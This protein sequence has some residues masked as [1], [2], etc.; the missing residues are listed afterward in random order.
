MPTT[1]ADDAPAAADRAPPAW[2][3]LWV[4]LAG[5]PA[6]PWGV[7]GLR[8]L[9]V[10][11]VQ[12]GW[13]LPGGRVEAGETVPEAAARELL[14]ETGLE[15]VVTGW[16]RTDDGATCHV[17]VTTPDATAWSSPDPMIDRVQWCT[18]PP[19]PLAWSQQELVD[20]ADRF[21]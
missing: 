15:G 20:A 13:E 19:T 14:E 11:H 6:G 21:A 5:G 8:W 18:G 3:A 12:R 10:R 17:L 7:D 16:V 2:V 1:E 4:T 9:M